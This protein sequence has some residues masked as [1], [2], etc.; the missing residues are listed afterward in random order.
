MQTGSLN[1]KQKI[2]SSLRPTIINDYIFCV[3][4]EGYLA[5]IEK[6]TG[7]IIRI[8]DIFHQFK[9]KKRIKI[10]PIG[11]MVGSENIYIA[12]NNGRL[13]EVDISSGKTKST[14]KIN[15]KAISRPTVINKNL[16]TIS[17]NSIIKLN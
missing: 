9:S 10:K 16:Y 7:N 4:E 5:V 13:L 15:S 6:N 3:T 11:F 17:E 8:T 14:I 2:N 12:T 1:W